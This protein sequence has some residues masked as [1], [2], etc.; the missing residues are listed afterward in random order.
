VTIELA[1]LKPLAEAGLLVYQAD[2]DRCFI[3]KPRQDGID[4][5]G[6]ILRGWPTIPLT[7]WPQQLSDCNKRGARY[8]AC[9]R[10]DYGPDCPVFATEGPKGQLG[11]SDG[12]WWFMPGA[13]RLGGRDRRPKRVFDSLATALSVIIRFYANDFGANCNDEE[14]LTRLLASV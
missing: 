12:C 4:R 7:H 6:D 5:G 9:Y 1:Q 14:E 13:L 3:W 11:F 10:E 2:P 8:L